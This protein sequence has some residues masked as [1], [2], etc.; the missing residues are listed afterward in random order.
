MARYL[1]AE[2]FA[3]AARS[4]LL[5]GPVEMVLEQVVRDTPDGQVV[6]RV[7]VAGD[8]ARIVWPVPEDAPAADLRISTDWETAVSVA[9]GDLSTQRALMQG[10][11]RISVGAG[12]AGGASG[13]GGAGA[14]AGV[15]AVPAGV[16]QATTFDV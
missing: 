13:A 4:G 3:S 5:P 2:W 12:G 9:R 7:E 16:R 1:S 11:L 15:D 10:R 8:Q 6:Y 14:L